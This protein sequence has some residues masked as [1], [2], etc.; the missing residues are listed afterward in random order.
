M[1]EKYGISEEK[2]EE[3][4][5]A[6]IKVIED[7]SSYLFSL[8]HSQPYSYEGYVSGYLRTYYPVEFLTV[9]LN[10]NKDKEEKTRGL[11]AYVKSHGIKLLPPKFR[12]SQSGYF[13]DV[14]NKAIYK[15]IGS[16]KF[17][18]D[19]V[20]D[21]LYELRDNQYDC[22][23]SLLVDLKEKTTLNARQLDYPYQDRLL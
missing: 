14:K 18:N 23:G 19:Q 17:M 15:G 16:I 8:N 5:V 20:A 6:F 3:D 11:I 12:H 2:S 7:A 22:F 1:K 13:C 9:A 4:I 21:Q 10:I